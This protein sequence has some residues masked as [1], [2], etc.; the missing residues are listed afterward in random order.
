[1]IRTILFSFLISVLVMN[2]A[3]ISMAKADES[4]TVTFDVPGMTCRVCPITIRKALEKVKGVTEAKAS[5][6]TKTA[7]VTFD[8]GKT[9]IE[10][11]TKAMANAGYPSTLKQ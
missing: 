4:K 3:F 6:D 9:N 7:T 11:L 5:F 8:P 1:M 10:A 2:L